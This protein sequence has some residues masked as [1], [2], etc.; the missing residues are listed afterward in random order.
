MSNSIIPINVED[1]L[2][3]SYLDYA[4]SV[5]VGRALPDARDGL[6]PVHRRVLYA[7]HNLKNDWNKPYKKSARVV[8]DVMGKYHPHG[9]TAIYDTIV[10]MAQDFSM[11]H[12]LIDGQGNFGSV[13]GDAAAAMRYTEIRLK[14]IAHQLL[15]DIDKKTVDFAPNYDNT[16][17]IPE[18]L[19]TRIPNLLVNGS[20]GI[21]VGMATNIPPHNL[22]EVIDS[23][24]ALLANPEI[25][26]DELLTIMPGPDFPTGGLIN[27]R[28]G[29]IQAYKTG[30]GI[31]KVRAKHIIEQHNNRQAI[32]ITELPYQ[33]NKAKLIQKIA[34]LSRDKKVEGIAELRD[35]SD[36]DG[37]RIVIELKRNETPEII[38]NNL[39]LNS[40]LQVSFGIN[41]VALVDKRPQVLNLKQLLDIFLSHRQEVI[42]RRT[43]F[44][45]AKARNRGHILEGLAI[46]LTN[47]DP[48]IQLIK[49]SKTSADAKAALLA[50]AWPTGTVINLL[51]ATDTDICRPA[52]LEE[53]YG[54]NGSTYM[55][56]PAQAQAILD[57]KLH[58]LTGMEQDKLITEY[59]EILEYIKHLLEILNNKTT[60]LGIIKEEL[61]AEKEK[62]ANERRTSIDANEQDLTIADLITKQEMIVTLSEKGYIKTQ[63]VSDYNAQNR[64]GKGKAATA[65]KEEDFV[66]CLLSAHSH[67]TILCFSNLGK[68]YWKKVYEIPQASRTAKGKP[69]NNLLHL[70]EGENITA[71]L[72]LDYDANHHEEEK[73]IL[74]TTSCGVVK[75]TSIQAFAR[76]RNTGLIAVNLDEGDKLISVDLVLPGD[77]I[78]LFSSSGKVTRFNQDQVRAVGRTARGV[79]GI[80]LQSGHKVIS[81]IIPE[82]NTAILTVSENG[83]G[84]RTKSD[85]FPVYNR[86]GQGLLAMNASLRNGI[87]VGAV[88]VHENDNVMLISNKGTFVKLRVTDIPTLGRNTQGVKL[89]K[90]ADDEKLSEVERI[91]EL[92]EAEP[93]ETKL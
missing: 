76:P 22:G 47:I 42:T 80:K 38:I 29:I 71:M 18:V 86:G 70:N 33:V 92:K 14:K 79:R 1:E 62:F 90:V 74:M 55:L 83:F 64:G 27:G 54:I 45:L 21:A 20:S 44:E 69:I 87:I 81:T 35:E 5:I 63:P 77:E 40:Q 7:M 51:Q 16:E 84:K 10:R 88:Q 23:C 46:A 13:D 68:V 82:K 19:P 15:I 61:L 52:N 57:L 85:K 56:S 28:T 72:P 8:G 58:R 66:M 34:E 6:K 9:D 50:N 25:S 26:I 37:M 43:I 3:K 24:I 49:E 67:D 32:I 4:M 11:R 91:E 12:I 36:K 2:R 78:M 89:I 39:Y 73:Y 48:I 31:I 17:Q 93:I 75:K 41:T 60:L 53:K 30:R 65:V 59:K